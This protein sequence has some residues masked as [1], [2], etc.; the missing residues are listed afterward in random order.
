MSFL[1]FINERLESLKINLELKKSSP[2]DS[3]IKKSIEV[4]AKTKGIDLSEAQEYFNEQYHKHISQLGSSKMNKDA[5]NNAAESI[6]F[7]LISELNPDDINLEPLGVKDRED[8]LDRDYF[9]DLTQYVL[10]ENARFFPLRN[11]FETKAVKPFFFITP[12]HLPLINDKK[13]RENARNNCKTAFCTP[14]AEMVFNRKFSETLAISALINNVKPKSKKYKSNGGPIP[15]HY[16]YLEFVIL[17]ELMH[18]SSGDHF[19]TKKMVDKILKKHPKIGSNANSVLNYVG[20]FINNWELVKSGYEQLPVGLFSSE[21]N[22]DKFETYE[23]MIEAV[24]EEFFNQSPEDTE[25]MKQS[26]ESGMDDHMD[27]SDDTPSQGGKDS[28]S[29]DQ[30]GQQGQGQ[31]G[32]GQ[33]GQGQDQQDQPGQDQGQDQGQGQG[34]QGQGQQGQQDQ[35]GQDQGQQDQSGQDQGQQ[36]QGQ[37][38]Q[39]QSGQDQ[40]QQGQGQGQ[41]GQPGQD[42]GQQ[43]QGQGQSG[44]PGQSGQGNNDA[45]PADKIAKSIDEAMKKNRENISK[46]DDGN[47]DAKTA[48]EKKDSDNTSVKSNIN[49]SGTAK[50]EFDDTKV[51]INWKKILKKMIPTG[52]GE[53]EDTYSK[54]SRQATSSMVTASQTGA[55]RITPG[56]VVFD[57][58]K[59]GL[60]F[61]ID[62]SGSVMNVV[63]NFNKEILKLLK[64][65]K[66][67]LSNMFVIK[68]STDFEVHKV[69]INAMESEKLINHDV[70]LTKPK[71][72]KYGQKQQLQKLLSVGYASGTKYI[73][74]MHKIIEY[75]HE[76]NM[77][78]IMFTDADLVHDK[79]TFKFFK[80]AKVRKNSVALFITD[81]SSYDLMSKTYGAHK[82]MTI[83][84]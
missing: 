42:Q 35:S 44:Q 57:S 68:F 25:K 82:W 7:S 19:Y 3:N 52:N 66:K 53:A 54:M 78:I 75:F 39:D 49:S 64:D 73:P 63:G 74:Q 56:E 24:I 45:H 15:D 76:N 6:A 17:H 2:N 34:Q 20:D 41:S 9:F 58:N 51:T 61:V 79:E 1:N 11:P 33:Q 12:D 23:D 27:N 77:N 48:L 37:G 32:K 43:G 8:L 80:L 71:D 50:I 70:L 30:Q 46:R 81:K 13:L 67:E 72:I 21:I 18:F 26:M 60:V 31:Q 83:L 40:G 22:Y 84:E 62:T 36:G 16:C 65:N 38:Q 55:G 69:N 10:G 29:G 14:N 59:K 28:Q 47:D 5:V 4:Y